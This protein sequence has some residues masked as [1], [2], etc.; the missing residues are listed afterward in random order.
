MMS[1]QPA[2]FE[3]WPADLWKGLKVESTLKIQIIFL[4]LMDS[5]ASNSTNYICKLSS[6]DEILLSIV[7]KAWC[8]AIFLIFSGKLISDNCAPCF[9]KIW[10]LLWKWN[11]HKRECNF[12]CSYNTHKNNI[13]KH[14][15]L[16]SRS[17]DTF[18][19]NYD[20]VILLGDFNVCVDDETMK[21]FCNSYCI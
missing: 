12:N 1:H 2:T 15:E 4:S 16:I 20:D 6:N 10:L 14:L 7:R 13:T 8:T 9:S 21:A 18:S 3:S 17:S 19:M 11:P 5:F